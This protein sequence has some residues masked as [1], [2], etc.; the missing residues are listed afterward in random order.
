MSIILLRGFSH[1]GK[2]FVGDILCKK[3]GYER[4]AFADS[5]KK[6]I[7]EKYQCNIEQLHTQSGKLEV[8]QS[9]SKK[10]TFRQILIEEALSLR[11]IDCDIFA[12][13]CCKDISQNVKDNY[14]IVITDWRYPNELEVLK[15][16]FPNYKIYPVH[17][18]RIHQSESPILDIS[19]YHLS[20]R[21]GDY[22]IYNSIDDT[23]Y[24]EVSNLINNIHSE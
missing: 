4:F 24:S 3:Y 2:D 21:I 18:K 10:R 15:N 1:S 23:I 14:K 22:T 19:E 12:K 11:N 5:L 16:H 20:D 8:C 6:I 17:I 7:V 9:D 13:L